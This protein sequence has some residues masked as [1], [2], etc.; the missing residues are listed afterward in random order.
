VFFS[1]RPRPGRDRFLP[2]KLALLTVGGVL[3]LVGMRIN[4]SLLVSIAIAVV[5]VG[6]LL[7]FVRQPDVNGDAKDP[8]N[9]P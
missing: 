1:R 4:S 6:F 7:R 2:A 5:L 3:G 8:L 9:P